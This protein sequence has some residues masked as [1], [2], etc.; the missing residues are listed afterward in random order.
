M[1]M[2]R[3]EFNRRERRFNLYIMYQRRV[4]RWCITGVIVV[5][6]RIL[7][8]NEIC[9]IR[10]HISDRMWPAYSILYSVHLF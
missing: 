3:Q 2:A 1:P 10:L 9:R 4:W 7:R 8:Q 5:H 6:S